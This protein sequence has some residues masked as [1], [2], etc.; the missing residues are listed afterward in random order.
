M[1]H[2]VIWILLQDTDIK[3]E[4]GMCMGLILGHKSLRLGMS[5]G[6]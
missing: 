1:A 5:L 6:L 4:V 3:K 2:S